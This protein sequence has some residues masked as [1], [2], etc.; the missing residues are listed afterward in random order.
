M[1]E[2]SKLRRKYKQF[3]SEE[4]GDFLTLDEGM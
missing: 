2:F 1:Q 3:M 4:M